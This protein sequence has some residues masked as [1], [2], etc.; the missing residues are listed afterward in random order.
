MIRHQEEVIICCGCVKPDKYD[1]DYTLPY[2]GY[3]PGEAMTLE[4]RL[5]NFT[6]YPIYL[7]V[8]LQMVR[9]IEI[10]HENL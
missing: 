2:R 7:C 9:K 4:I 3:V 8:N 1:I 5:R 10:N 6:R